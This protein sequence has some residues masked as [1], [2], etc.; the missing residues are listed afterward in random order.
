MYFVCLPLET[1]LTFQDKKKK[2]QISL[3]FVHFRLYNHNNFKTCLSVDSKRD[4]MFLKGFYV[5]QT[6]TI[7]ALHVQRMHSF[8]NHKSIQFCFHSFKVEY[9]LGFGAAAVIV[10]TII[11]VLILYLILQCRGQQRKRRAARRRAAGLCDT[12]SGGGA[13]DSYL[14]RSTVDFIVP[15]TI[16][17]FRVSSYLIS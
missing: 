11:I 8:V 6:N 14:E 17:L 3:Q 9:I 15:G 5:L 16:I 10:L 2:T 1:L 13:G 4:I 7:T 12:S